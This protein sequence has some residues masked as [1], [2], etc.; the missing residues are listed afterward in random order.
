[1]TDEASTLHFLGKVLGGAIYPLFWLFAL[2]IPLW[3]VRKYAPKA[4]WWLYTPI[5][6]VIRRLAGS[7]RSGSPAAHQIEQERAALRHQRPADRE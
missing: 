5:S 1:M 6:Q 4:E 2:S 3:L 7:L